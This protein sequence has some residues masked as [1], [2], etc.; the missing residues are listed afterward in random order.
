VR[1]WPLTPPFS[2]AGL[3][4]VENAKKRKK[5]KVFSLIFV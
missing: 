2:N 4:G 3:A 5:K 1:R